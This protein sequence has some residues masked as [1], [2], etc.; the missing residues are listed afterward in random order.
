MDCAV[1]DGRWDPV[2]GMEVAGRALGLLGVGRIGKL[3]AQNI[4]TRVRGAQLAVKFLGMPPSDID[5]ARSA[6]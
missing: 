3:H 5:I 4:A 2:G 1:R 6:H